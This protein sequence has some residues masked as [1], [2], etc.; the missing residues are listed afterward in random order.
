MEEVNKFGGWLQSWHY[1]NAKE[2]LLTAV[3]DVDRFIHYPFHDLHV[4]Q[5]RTWIVIFICSGYA[6]ISTRAG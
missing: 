3:G 5:Y 1:V 2:F 4:Q 6:P